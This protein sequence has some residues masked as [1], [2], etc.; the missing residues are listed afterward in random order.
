MCAHMCI[1]THT[2]AWHDKTE[3]KIWESRIGLINLNVWM[4]KGQI[5]EVLPFF[6]HRPFFMFV[7][8]MVHRRGGGGG[9]VVDKTISLNLS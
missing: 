5:I 6:F 3:I 9:S 1:I 2:A 4:I 7:D 8:V